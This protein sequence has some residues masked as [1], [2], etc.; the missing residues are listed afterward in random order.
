MAFRGDELLPAAGLRPDT[1][2]RRPAPLSNYLLAFSGLRPWGR[3]SGR[4]GRG[5][6]RWRPPAALPAFMVR[7]A[8][9]PR[10]RLGAQSRHRAGPG[11]PW[12]PGR[13][14]PAPRDPA[15]RG[16]IGRPWLP[17]SRPQRSGL[18]L[19]KVESACP[20]FDPRVLFLPPQAAA[21]ETA[22]SA[23]LACYRRRRSTELGKGGWA[24]GWVWGSCVVPTRFIYFSLMKLYPHPLWSFCLPY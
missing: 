17:R 24:G 7:A 19:W 18:A 10:A 8:G 9:S 13:V 2:P 20:D 22:P 5:D 15:A 6:S 14:P 1:Q 12:S 4:R 16:P 23:P 21:A 3:S 11:G